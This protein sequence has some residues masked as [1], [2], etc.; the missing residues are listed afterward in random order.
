MW[1]RLIISRRKNK[2]HVPVCPVEKELAIMDA[3]KHFRMLNADVEY[4]K[5]NVE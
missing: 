3:L 4:R 5:E 2:N 1:E